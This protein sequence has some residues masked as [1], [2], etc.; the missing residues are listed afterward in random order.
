[1]TLPRDTIVA[2]D[3]ILDAFQHSR[4]YDYAQDLLPDN[5][6]SYFD[7]FR[8]TLED[9]FD[10]NTSVIYDIADWAWWCMGALA[11]MA[12]CFLIWRNRGRLFAPR[13]V[14]LKAQDI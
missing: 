7:R 9:L 8:N 12:V 13:D 11:V 6:T 5:E 3:S 1:M 10:I 2:N 4:K 14:S